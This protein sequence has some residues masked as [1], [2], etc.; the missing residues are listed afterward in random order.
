FSIVTGTKITANTT[1]SASDLSYDNKVV[2]VQSGTSTIV[3]NHTFD[4]LI[5]LDGATVTHPATDA[6]TTQK[7][8]INT[9]TALFVSCTGS[10]DVSGRGY[11]AGATYPGATA[12]G[13]YSSGS[14]IGVGGFYQSPISTTFGSVYQ[15]QEA[16]GGANHCCTAGGGIVTINTPSLINDGAVRANGTGNGAGGCCDGAAGGSIWI[17]TTALSGAGAV[18]AQGGNWDRTGGGGAI[19]IE[20]AS[21][22]GSMLSNLRAYTGGNAGATGGQFGGAGSIYVKGPN[23]TYGALTINNNNHGGALNTD[24]PSLGSGIAQNG[25]T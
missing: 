3:G 11:P 18:E 8:T 22:T 12:P 15:P 9:T 24:L 13:N 16:G 5:V 10:I 1:I 21:S 17:R 2:I 25:T 4:T 23:A 7:L 14:H 19:A 20:Y 6:V